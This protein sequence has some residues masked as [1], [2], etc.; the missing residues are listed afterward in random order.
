MA[1]ARA[2]QYTAQEVLSSVYEELLK[3]LTTSLGTYLTGEDSNNSV[4]KVEVDRCANTGPLT[5]D[6]LV[7]P[8]AG[9][10]FGIFFAAAASTP[11]CKIW[12][13]TSAAGTVIVNTF[14]PAAA[15]MYRFP[16]AEFNTGLFI[17]IGGTVDYTVFYR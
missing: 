12:D 13:N 14:T 4:F 17:D 1:K 5:A 2:V 9:R 10:L 6:Q 15:T 8:G 11:T 16:A 3:V 7:K